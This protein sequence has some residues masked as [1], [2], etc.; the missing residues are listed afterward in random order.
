MKVICIPLF[1]A[2]VFSQAITSDTPTLES[3]NLSAEPVP[4][5]M[6][7]GAIDMDCSGGKDIQDMNF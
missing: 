3:L 4:Y 2:V 7:I 5:E 6:H 1:A